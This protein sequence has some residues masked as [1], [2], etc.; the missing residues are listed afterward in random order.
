MIKRARVYFGNGGNPF[1]VGEQKKGP[2]KAVRPRK[3]IGGKAET[4]VNGGGVS[5]RRVLADAGMRSGSMVRVGHTSA[6]VEAKV[7]EVKIGST[8]ELAAVTGFSAGVW[9]GP[10]GEVEKSEEPRP[11]GS[12]SSKPIEAVGMDACGKAAEEE[13]AA[14]VE[15]KSEQKTMVVMP[16]LPFVEGTGK[17]KRKR[18]RGR[19]RREE[20]GVGLAITESFG[21]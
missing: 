3:A 21:A 5:M 2:V 19:H 16:E 13:E 11:T 14:A 1:K 6:K 7:E 9:G 10:E 15:P 20:S 12:D 17:R 8:A 4:S 18:R